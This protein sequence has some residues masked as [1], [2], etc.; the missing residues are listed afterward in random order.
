M[1][2][3]R[4]RPV[5]RDLVLPRL[6]KVTGVRFVEDWIAFDLTN[7]GELR[8][9]LSA[10]PVLAAASPEL[11]AEWR[12]WLDGEAVRWDALDEDISVR[13]LLTGED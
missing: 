9:P 5:R 6:P 4:M 13:L 2:V 11:R 7:G 12:I 3:L 10:F 1:S 8:F